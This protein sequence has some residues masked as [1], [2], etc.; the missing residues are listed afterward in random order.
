MERRRES[1]TRDRV[2]RALIASVAVVASLAA[3][4]STPKTE[5]PTV[6]PA[7]PLA[8]RAFGDTA[9]W[10]R[11]SILNTARSGAFSSDRAIREYCR[12][13]WDARAVPVAL[14]S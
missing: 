2:Q 14:A 8:M 9:H 10:T 13:I 7:A 3:C 12:D 5:A 6:A 11:M 1:S 4:R